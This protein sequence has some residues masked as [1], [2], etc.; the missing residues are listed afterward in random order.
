[1]D[2]EDGRRAN[3]HVKSAPI[4][5]GYARRVGGESE[6]GEKGGGHTLPAASVGVAE[7][8]SILGKE[9]RTLSFFTVL[10]VALKVQFSKSATS[11]F[12]TFEVPIF[13]V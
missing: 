13:N 11:S 2:G 1:M 4:D 6:E 3:E 5:S 7:A 9:S 8:A 10:A 12:K